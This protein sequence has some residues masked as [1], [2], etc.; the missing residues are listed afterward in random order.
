[1]SMLD[2]VSFSIHYLLDSFRPAPAQTFNIQLVVDLL[3]AFSQPHPKVCRC[4]L[5]WDLRSTSCL[6]VSH[7]RHSCLM[8]E[9]IL[10]VAWLR[11]C[12]ISI[13]G[14][15]LGL[16]KSSFEFTSDGASIRYIEALAPIHKNYRRLVVPPKPDVQCCPHFLGYR[17]SGRKAGTGV[18][19]CAKK[20]FHNNPIKHGQKN[21]PLTTKS[22]QVSTRY[23]E[24]LCLLCSSLL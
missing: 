15:Q 22:N 3:A 12:A 6:S 18:G 8:Q 11:C 14:L 20:T 5:P 16:F 24:R 7:P 17:L 1:M 4:F 19:T 10:H 13:I 23:L 9:N 21:V 2:T